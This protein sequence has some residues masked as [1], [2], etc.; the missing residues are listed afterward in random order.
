MASGS[1]VDTCVGLLLFSPRKSTSALRPPV[2]GSLPSPPSLGLR[3]FRLAQASMSVPSTEKCCDDSSRLTWGWVKMAPRN[4]AAISPSSRLVV[5]R[6]HRVIPRPI[7]DTE[8][9]EPA[10]QQIE[11]QPLHQLTFRA[12]RVE[13]LQQRGT[14][15]LLRWNGRSTKRRIECCKITAQL[16]QG[17]IGNVADRP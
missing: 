7:I 6:E 13:G 10:E 3:L 15:Q 16:T 1:L 4:L 8:T 11:L 9:N 12:D 17:V 14:Q 2:G 5:L